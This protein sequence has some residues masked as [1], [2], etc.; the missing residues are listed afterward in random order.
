MELIAQAID[1]AKENAKINKLDNTQFFVGKAEEVLSSICYKA[2]GKD[3]IG[4]IDP[5]RAGLRKY[6][7]I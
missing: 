1:D 5:P 3:V 2:K 4:I 7:L 6:A